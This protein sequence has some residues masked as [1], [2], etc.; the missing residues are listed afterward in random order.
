MASSR[1]MRLSD[2]LDEKSGVVPPDRARHWILQLLEALTEVHDSGQVHGSVC[3]SNILI[4]EEDNLSLRLPADSSACPIEVSYLSPEQV[5]GQ[6]LDLRTDIYSAGIVIFRLLTGVH[7]YSADN[8]FGWRLAHLEQ[9]PQSPRHCRPDLPIKLENELLRAL[10]KDRDGRQ[11]NCRALVERL[12]SEPLRQISESDLTVHEIESSISDSPAGKKTTETS[13]SRIKRPL[14]VILVVVAAISAFVLRP[15]PKLSRFGSVASQPVQPPLL[16]ESFEHLWNEFQ[17]TAPGIG[18]DNLRR[19]ASA[20][21]SRTDGS[22]AVLIAVL[23]DAG[24]YAEAERLARES[25]MANPGEGLWFELL[26]EALHNQKRITEA[27]QASQTAIKLGQNSLERTIREGYHHLINQRLSDA[28]RLF[29]EAIQLRSTYPRL[30]SH[31]AA[32]YSAQASQFERN[33]QYD[34]AIE[35]LDQAILL[36]PSVSPYHYRIGRLLIRIDKFNQ[37]ETHLRDSIRL[38]PQ[39]ADCYNDLGMV[40]DALGRVDDAVTAINEALR[41]NPDHIQARENLVHLN[42]VEAK[43]NIPLRPQPSQS[44]RIHHT[45]PFRPTPPFRIRD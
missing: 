31:L 5:I 29:R 25:S 8:E 4:D 33:G 44:R 6:P 20:S 21:G 26:G 14:A 2:L 30:K 27:D 34:Q 32:V 42:E 45:P 17:N 18:L 19:A 7:P 13:L 15:E 11:P 16:S 28:E 3:P 40:L 22:R 38:D 10:K 23:I 12:R 1:N 24:D 35:R 9:T 37:A 39:C 36:A 41:L 43:P